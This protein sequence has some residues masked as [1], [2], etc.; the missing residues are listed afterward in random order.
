MGRRRQKAAMEDSNI[1]NDLARSIELD[2]EHKYDGDGLRLHHP[3]TIDSDGSR[4]YTDQKE[5]WKTKER[6]GCGSFGE[7]QLQE[8][9]LADGR[10]RQRAVKRLIF[11]D[12]K[13]REVRAIASL[14][15]ADEVCGLTVRL[16]D[17]SH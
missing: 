6:L 14:L 13:F 5:W 10:R 7:V 8:C 3:F 4:S 2:V 11:T 17:A 16:F 12:Q 1:V 9:D 15:R